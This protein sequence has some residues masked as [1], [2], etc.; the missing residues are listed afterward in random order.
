MK[1]RAWRLM[2]FAAV[3]FLLASSF[4]LAQPSKKRLALVG[5]MLIDGYD[6]PPVHHAAIVI[7]DNKIVQVGPAAEVAIPPDAEVIDTSGRVM[8]PGLIDAARP[9]PDPGARRL[10]PVGPLDREEQP[11]REGLGDLGEAAADG[12]RHVGRGPRRAR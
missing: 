3:L 5:G 9:S 2:V 6:V 1:L 10:R 12:G 11:G 7:E 4:A 8:M